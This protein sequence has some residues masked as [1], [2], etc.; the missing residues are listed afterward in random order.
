MLAAKRPTTQQESKRTGSEL[1]AKRKGGD[2]MG[3]PFKPG[4][5]LGGEV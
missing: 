3:G 5:G 1:A 2:W 4:F